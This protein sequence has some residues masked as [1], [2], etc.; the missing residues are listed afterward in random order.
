MRSR[1]SRCREIG[2]AR[3]FRRELGIHRERI[4]VISPPSW[5][6]AQLHA[7][8]SISSFHNFTN[9]LAPSSWSPSARLSMSMSLANS[10]ST[11]PRQRVDWCRAL[12]D[13]QCVQR[14]V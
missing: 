5:A 14:S 12:G 7:T 9:H 3:P 1:S 13:L 8:A 4:L 2:S 6:R 10:V 11:L